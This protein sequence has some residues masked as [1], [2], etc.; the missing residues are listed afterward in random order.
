MTAIPAG[1]TPKQLPWPTSKRGVMQ[2]AQTWYDP[3]LV[4]INDD[5][6]SGLDFPDLRIGADAGMNLGRMDFDLH[7]NLEFAIAINSIN[8]QFWDLGD[9]GDFL[10]YD[11]EGIVGAAGMRMAFIRAWNDP[12]SALSSARNGSA[13]TEDGVRSVFGDIP[14]ILGRVRILN[15]VLLPSKLS[16][17]CERLSDEIGC[18]AGVDVSMARTIAETFPEAYGDLVLKKAQLA[19]SEVW[20]NMAEAHEH[21]PVCDLTAFADYQIPSV[22]RALGVLTYSDEL[23]RKIDNHELISYESPEEN[24]IRGAS[25]LAVQKIADLLNVPVASVDHYLWTRRKEALAP[26][27]LTKTTAY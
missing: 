25:L 23:A 3:N 18:V 2:I 4:N 14:D 5:V 13:L 24:A 12:E 22:L 6:I 17:L 7:E 27:H 1:R 26:F 8:Y 10:R 19:L 15:E 21:T 16:D 11:F 9:Q 20:V